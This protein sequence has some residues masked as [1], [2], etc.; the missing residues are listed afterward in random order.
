MRC[1][2]RLI[3]RLSAVALLTI[4]FVSVCAHAGDW[5]RWR[6]PFHNGSAD[7]K[8]LPDSLTN[9]LWTS[10]LPGASGA[11]PIVYAGRVFVSSTDS[12]DEGSFLAMCFDAKT[13]KELWR[14]QIGKDQR[15]FP[16]NNMATPSPVTDGK[17]VFFLFGSGDLAALDYEGKI[18]WS[19]DIQEEYANLSLKYGYSNSPLFYEGRL[20]ILV[21]RRPK[22]YRKPEPNGPLDSFILAINPA[23]GKNL[24]K[25]E[26]TTDAIN[27]SFDSY[28]TP[29]IFDSGSRTEFV[30]MGG[31]YIM[32]HDP[33]TGKELWRYDY[34]PRK[35]EKWRNIP[36]AV[37]GD[38]LI[39]SVRARAGQLTALKSGGCGRLTD[40]DVAW[41]FDGPTTDSSTPTYYKQNLYVLY[42]RGKT[43]TCLD[44]K[45]GK[46]KWQGK[47][48]GRTTYYASVT[49]ADD[50]LY[51]I[52]EGGDAVVVAAGGN[53]FRQ[54]SQ[55][56]FDEGPTRSTI[57]AAN[58][59]LFV[60]TAKKLYCFGK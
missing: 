5:P 22:I 33:A 17:R 32:S 47:L 27:E 11:T 57:A 37:S 28:A 25:I 39:F 26:R 54:I 45:T 9:P 10:D 50:K 23:T 24:W 14:K 4:V 1:F 18:A 48:P 59:R 44:A 31:D 51:C 53:E 58:S 38:G 35:E 20:Y 49:A 6:G 36:S 30:T 21:M 52:S 55:A 42:G 40:A 16:R 7:E 8:G 43:L 29:I 3:G 2:S 34:N 60:R 46:Q 15:K 19:R 12:G 56:S 13:G 41:T